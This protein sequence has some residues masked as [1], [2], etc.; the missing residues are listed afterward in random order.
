MIRKDPLSFEVPLL[1]VATFLHFQIAVAT[2]SKLLHLGAKGCGTR[3]GKTS[4]L[5]SCTESGILNCIARDLKIYSILIDV[6]EY[7]DVFL[8]FFDNDVFLRF[9]D[10]KS[11]VLYYS[12]RF[13][14]QIAM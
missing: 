9:F 7:C 6:F 10:N 3:S 1:C 2:C 14:C 13:F 5:F 8:R 11:V 12:V 4:F